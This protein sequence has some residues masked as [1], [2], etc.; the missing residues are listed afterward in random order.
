MAREAD[1]TFCLSVPADFYAV[2]QFFKNFSQVSD[3]EV[4]AVLQKKEPAIS[5]VN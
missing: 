4:I 2:G 3:E 1:D 5:A